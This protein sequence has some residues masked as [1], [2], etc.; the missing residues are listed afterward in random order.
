[1]HVR[2]CRDC[3]EEYRPEIVS[4]GDCGGKLEDRYEADQDGDPD[5][6]SPGASPRPPEPEVPELTGYCPIFSTDQAPALVPL[7]ERLRD[8]GMAFHLRESASG[9]R[10]SAARYHLL[11]PV[12]DADQ[13]RR[14]LAPLLGEGEGAQ[15]A[16]GI[17]SEF[18][19]GSY[20]RCPACGAPLSGAP[21]ECPGCGL[22][23][24]KTED[25][26]TR[27]DSTPAACARCGLLLAP[28]QIECPVCGAE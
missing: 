5:S 8:A 15:P 14:E 18:A 28:G 27:I 2:V 13:A 4:C 26:A 19:D 25:L 12:S 3:G 23:L 16:R 20:R 11:V 22:A 7:A 9:S 1:V 17:D 24:G 21:L 10:R 6:P